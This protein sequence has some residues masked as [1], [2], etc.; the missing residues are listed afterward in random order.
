LSRAVEEEELLDFIFAFLNN[1][2]D[3]PPQFVGRKIVPNLT[4]SS[5]PLCGLA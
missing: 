2:G 5:K 1:C 4:E 3:Q